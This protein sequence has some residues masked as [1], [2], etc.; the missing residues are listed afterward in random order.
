MSSIRCRPA[1]CE[2]I[3]A[4]ETTVPVLE[5]GKTRTGRLWT[6]VR[7]DR[8]FTGG[9]HP[10]PAL[11]RRR[12]STSSRLIAQRRI[13]RRIWPPARGLMQAD[14]YSGYDRLQGRPAARPDRRSSPAGPN[15][16]RY[17]FDLARL[18]KAPIACRELE[19]GD[20]G[21]LRRHDPMRV[22]A[23]VA[24]LPTVEGQRCSRRR[25]RR[26]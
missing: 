22:E 16:R 5:V 2:R 23:I 13:P 14:A 1:C 18:N 8:P 6:Y 7:D 10:A 26:R 20:P 3:H 17:F 9:R 15:A 24:K 11:I 4:D 21:S 25:L 19:G 12:R